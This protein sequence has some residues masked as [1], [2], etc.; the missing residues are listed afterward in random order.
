MM[1]VVFTGC[2]SFPGNREQAGRPLGNSAPGKP[3][4]YAYQTPGR[5]DG[6]LWSETEG[7]ALYPDR[8]A[9][10]VG[11][12]V[13]VRIVEDPEA[14][15]NANTK[16]SRTSSVDASKLEILGFM[17]ALAEKNRRL[18]QNPGQGDL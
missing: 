11:D 3:G 6:S 9:R 2:A 4:E 5:A 10:Q 18:A 7:L 14:Q 17:K 1:L 13:I 8:R 16:T 15:L 12:I